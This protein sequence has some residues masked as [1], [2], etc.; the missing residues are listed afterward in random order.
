MFFCCI[1]IGLL[2]FYSISNSYANSN[3]D[4]G[5]EEAKILFKK[6]MSYR[7]PPNNNDAKAFEYIK[8]SA[9]YN[10]LDA[11][12][13]LAQMFEEGVG[14]EADINKAIK[15]YTSAAKDGLLAAQSKLGSLYESGEEV[16]QN[17]N[18]A[19]EYY[20]MSVEQN[21][22][23]SQYRLGVI[24]EKGIG[25]IVIDYAKAITFYK[26]AAKNDDV[27]SQN[28]LGR[29]YEQGIG[30]PIDKVEALKWYM[31]AAENHQEINAIKNRD[32]LSKAL[33][34]DQIA[35]AYNLVK[36]QRLH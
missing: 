5:L 17:M 25:D 21:D 24:Y 12:F 14:V 36:K 23:F 13:A 22:P 16:E 20:K 34:K 35:K 4:S 2:T 33:T 7:F 6:G 10:F 1:L 9:N 15:W 28:A 29:I 30:V 18:L 3:E 32:R 26:M 11:K 27:L 8:K 31:I 19:I